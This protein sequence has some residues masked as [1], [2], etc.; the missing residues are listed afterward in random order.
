MLPAEIRVSG[1][2][3]N[4]QACPARTARADAG[5]S[6]DAKASSEAAAEPADATALAFAATPGLPVLPV[7]T[8]MVS[9]AAATPGEAAPSGD[10]LAPARLRESVVDMGLRVKGTSKHL[11]LYVTMFCVVAPLVFT[12]LGAVGAFAPVVQRQHQS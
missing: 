12:L 5:E 4:C 10:G 1:A 8:T 6:T 7:A 9:P 11:P 2:G 3:L